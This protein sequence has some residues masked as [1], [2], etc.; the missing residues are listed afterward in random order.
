MADK[1]NSVAIIGL[2]LLG[3]SLG[4]ALRGSSFHRIGWARRAE[5][6]DRAL[7][8]DAVDEVCDSIFAAAHA[9]KL[10]VLALP[11]PAACEYLMRGAELWEPGSVITDIGSVKQPVMAAAARL[12]N[13][14]I[15]FIGSHPMAGTE[16]SGLESAF[17]ELYRGADV[18]VTPAAD[19]PRDAVDRVFALWRAVGGIPGVIE[20][21]RH[22]DLV[23][24]T[25]HVL[26]VLASALASSILDAPDERTRRERFRGCATGFR[27]TSRIASSN[28]AMWREIIMQNQPAVLAALRDFDRRYEEIKKLIECGDFDGF[29]REFARG[30]ELRDRWLQYKNGQRH[31]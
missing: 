27:D 13:A 10:I 18:F 29:E 1:E 28:P 9:A 6:R 20:A 23:A 17:P 26:H 19:S 24:R 14:G 15:V 8:L 3:G 30:K 4:M 22:D 16:K 11:V 12:A 2:G 5:V 21:D 31:E 7:E 25:S